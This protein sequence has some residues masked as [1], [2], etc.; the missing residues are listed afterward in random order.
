MFELNIFVSDE[1]ILHEASHI[2]CEISGNI[3]NDERLN[4]K[5]SKGWLYKFK[6]RNGFKR[7]YCF[8]ESADLKVNNIV[9]DLPIILEELRN[10]SLNDI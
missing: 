4:M 7:Y 9:R 8:S 3:P 1:M 5:F 6:K 10:F 2:L